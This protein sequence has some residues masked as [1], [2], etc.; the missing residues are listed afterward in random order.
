MRRLALDR[1]GQ[2][3]GSLG[4]RTSRRPGANSS[5]TRGALGRGGRRVAGPRIPPVSSWIGGVQKNSYRL[6][7]SGGTR[8]PMGCEFQP[9][10]NPHAPQKPELGAS[11]R[12]GLSERQRLK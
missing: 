2:A 7:P 12:E 11:L 10:S 4:A 1:S 3:Q 9:K 8:R 5:R 6:L